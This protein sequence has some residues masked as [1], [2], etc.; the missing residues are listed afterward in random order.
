M[1]VGNGWG[2]GGP[3]GMG[4]RLV[5]A[6]AP[7]CQGAWWTSAFNLFVLSLIWRLELGLGGWACGGYAGY[8]C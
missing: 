1:L 7:C 8:C 6:N 4:G 2:G 3:V 5:A